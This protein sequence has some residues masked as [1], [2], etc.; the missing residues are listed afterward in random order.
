MEDKFQISNENNEQ[1]SLSIKDIFYKYLRFS[2]LFILSIAL[3]LFVAY[4]YL[5][6][7]TPIYS[8][9]GAL[10]IKD[11]QPLKGTD[12]YDAVLNGGNTKNLSDEIEVLKSRPLME[13]VVKELN[14]NFTYYAKGKIKEENRYTAA[15]FYIEAFE[16]ADSSNVFNLIITFTDPNTFTVNNEN[17][18]IHFGQ[19]FKNQFGVFRVLKRSE[20]AQAT[21][22]YRVSWTPTFSI[23][24]GLSSGLLVVPKTTGTGILLISL[25][26]DNPQFTADVI[27]GVMD[28]YQIVTL[29]DK[30]AANL[31]SKAFIDDRLKVV[32]HEVD[33]I[34]K[35]R[36]EYMKANNIIDPEV[37]GTNYLTDILNSDKTINTQ[38]AQLEMV[39]L[40][41]NYLQDKKN[42]YDPVHSNLVINDFTLGTMISGYNVAQLEH[43]AL[44]DANVPRQNI[45]VKQ[46]EDQIEKFRINIL[47]SLKNVKK[48]IGTNIETL[49]QQNL[50]ARTEAVKMPVKQQVL[51]DIKR[52]LASKLSVY[53]YLMEKRE[54]SS[55]AMAANI[56]SSKIVDQAFPNYAPIRPKRR[57][58]QL[59][60]FFVGLLIPALFIFIL[61]LLDDKITTRVDIVRLTEAPVLGEV[62]HSYSKNTLMVTP[63]NRGVIAE[64][65]RILRSN[66]QYVLTN[67]K[68][69]IILIT[70]TSSGEGKSFISTNVGAVMALA[71]KKTIILEFDVRKPKILSQLN[72]PKK[73]GLTNFMLGK[74]KP[75][76]LPIPVEN[77][78]NL[79]VLA[80]GPVPPNPAELLLDAKLNELFTWLRAN[81]DA[82]VMDTAPVGMVSDA[83]TLSKFADATLYI[84]RQGH[85]FKKQ[86][87]LIEEFHTNGKLPK[88]SV[89][90]NDVK[91]RTGYGYYG[92]GR[93]GYGKG[94]GYNSGYFE[95]ETPPPTIVE[96]WFGWMNVANWNGKKEN[97]TKV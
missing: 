70:S 58:I 1:T 24:S 84:V 12:K 7:A 38:R 90:L 20:Q 83:M 51:D 35:V 78:P 32:S 63:N 22:I 91:I 77:S 60:A 67:V 75:E 54:E 50:Q 11:D 4:I 66:L 88:V 10:I 26:T 86:I 53:N 82:I 73:P 59:T 65:F 61:E 29:E 16:L 43:R 39:Q 89:V 28:Q 97:K 31:R 94:Y 21:G 74:A 36:L 72:I 40:I 93:Y 68:N 17:T 49:Q 80:C 96:R 95:D 76:D 69:P 19:I 48:S 79:F 14:L 42:V 34:N 25:E 27:N 55:I 13:R 71:G 62:G 44:L 85:T 46:K 64:Q 5:R 56:T 45:L 9:T 92:Y 87:A 23:A 52:Q 37:Q 81:F 18:Q 30:N 33:S 8:A 2:P 41:E 47:E 6:Y 15:P 3:S 57:N